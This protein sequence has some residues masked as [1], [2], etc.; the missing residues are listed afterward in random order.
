[1]DH[2]QFAGFDAA[3]F[4]YFAQ[5]RAANRTARASAERAQATEKGRRLLGKVRSLAAA[6][7]EPLSE[8]AP[9]LTYALSRTSIGDFAYRLWFAFYRKQSKAKNEDAQMGFVIRENGVSIG[10]GFG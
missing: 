7:A 10:F 4:A 5:A 2:T 8:I 6:T 1:M 9:D 3:D